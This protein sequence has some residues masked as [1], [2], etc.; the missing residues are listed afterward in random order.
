MKPRVLAAFDKHVL[1]KRSLIETI[2][3]QLKN[4]FVLE[5]G[6]HRSLVNFVVNVPACRV[7]YSYQEKKPPLDLRAR[8][9]GF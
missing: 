7:A 1:R 9:Y 3:D 6:R 2:N 5:S 8:I 4:S